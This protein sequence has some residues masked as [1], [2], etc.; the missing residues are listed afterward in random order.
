MPSPLPPLP[1]PHYIVTC[2][3]PR[4]LRENPRKPI[5]EVPGDAVIARAAHQDALRKGLVSEVYVVEAP[6]G[7][8]RKL[9]RPVEELSAII[10]AELAA[11][12]HT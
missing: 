11:G 2:D 10:T 4:H 1:Y 7:P 6:D 3:V 9:Q 8:R 12:S 5:H